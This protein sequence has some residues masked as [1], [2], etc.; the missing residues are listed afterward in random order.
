[1]RKRKAFIVRLELP[2]GVTVDAA[3]RYVTDAVQG[4]KGGYEGDNPMVYLDWRTV[5]AVPA[6]PAELR[7]LAPRE[8]DLSCLGCGHP[9][10]KES[11]R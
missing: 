6:T 1:M 10:C 5:S 4:W 11:K 3:R 9:D 7:K 8:E 2:P